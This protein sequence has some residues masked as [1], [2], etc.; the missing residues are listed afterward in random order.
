MSV[1]R[2]QFIDRL[3]VKAYSERSIANYVSAVA[4]IAKY[5]NVS[6]LLLTA[7]QVR[8]YLLYLMQ[9]RELA[10]STINLQ[11][12]SLKTFF[13]IMA[14]GSTVMS[15]FS[16]L[17]IPKRVPVVLSREEVTRL[18]DAAKNLKRRAF[19]STMYCGGLRLMECC[20]LKP[21]HIDSSRMKIRV[22]QGKGRRDR[23][24]LL[25]GKTLDALRL[26]FRAYRPANWLFEGFNGNHISPRMAGKIVT[27]AADAAHLSKKVHPHTLRHSF[28]THL[29]EAG[30]ALP[31]IQRL[32]GHSSIKTTMIYLHVGMVL[33]DKVVSPMD[34][35]DLAACEKEE[36]HE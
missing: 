8:G 18:I 16:H 1:L 5:C 28:A 27:D 35:E 6:P 31:V 32:L 26:Y 14:P 25:S 23:Y 21:V 4:S 33:L 36:T 9:E 2:S 34:M 19:L 12:D 15:G 11:I 7:E 13:S 3:R 30:I 17:S 22:D 29:L 10:H 20:M 24:T